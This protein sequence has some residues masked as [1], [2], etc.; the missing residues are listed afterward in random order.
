MLIYK[1][2]RTKQDLKMCY[3]PPCHSR[4]LRPLPFRHSLSPRHQC[5]YYLSF[6][7]QNL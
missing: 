7:Q 4:V 1:A 2:S 6:C 5:H 3:F